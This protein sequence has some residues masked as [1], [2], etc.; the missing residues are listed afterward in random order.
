MFAFLQKLSKYQVRHIQF[1]AL[2]ISVTVATQVQYI[3]HGWINQDS[4]LYLEAAKLFS[5]GQWK[6]GFDIFPWP[7]YSLCIALV[8]QLTQLGVHI[9][10]QILNVIF[11]CVATFGFFR[12]I[13]LAGG[14]QRQMIAGA[15]V[16]FSG[17]YV[18][19]G[20]LEML[21][22][23][24]GFWAFYLLSISFLISYCQQKKYSDAL[25]WQLCMITATLFRIEA[26]TF[27]IFLPIVLLF[28]AG[29]NTKEKIKQLA[30][31]NTFNVAIAIGIIATFSLNDNLS[32]KFLGRLNEVF[33]TG[34]WQQFTL[35]ISEKSE[36]MSSQVLGEYLNE[37][38]L[39]GLLITFAYVI[40]FKTISATGIINV[41]LSFFTL[42]KRPSLI[43]PTAFSVLCGAAIIATFNMALII[44]KVFVLS[45]RYVL[46]LSFIL[47]I[48]SAFCLSEL[49]FNSKPMKKS[50]WLTIALVIFMLGSSVKNILPKKQGYNY[51]QE[52]VTWVIT[53]NT[54]DEPVFYDQ[55]R[56]RYYAGLPFI[57]TF[58]NRFDYL[59]SSISDKSIYQHNY[60]LIE[61]S[62]KDD[63]NTIMI[64]N[65]LPE[66]SL[67]KQF[68]D[69]QLKKCIKI[70]KKQP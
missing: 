24:V 40:L 60:L 25:L 15:L 59:E 11:F 66:Y 65:S 62:S 63:S 64:Q 19:G 30:C 12:I 54:D 8:N 45:G 5:V 61:A 55:A 42:K 4:V 23:D 70:Y 29:I 52:A 21:L 37:F 27:L 48:F 31:A 7:F 9:S 36:I 2:I 68:N 14:K 32:T 58:D 34:L 35:K 18:I 49:L 6:A 51:M 3:Q 39:E 22:R 10:A 16:W 69:A 38:A 1:A 28:Q 57:G 46:A 47:M 20:I 56:M 44:V 41:I 53:N 26:L 43:N 67:I 13:I 33:T 17:H 50:N